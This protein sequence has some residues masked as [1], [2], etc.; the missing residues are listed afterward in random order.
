MLNLITVATTHVS[1]YELG[2]IVVLGIIDTYKKWKEEKISK[3]LAPKVE[4]LIEDY[5]TRVKVGLQGR[6][7]VK[8]YSSDVVGKKWLDLI[9]E[10][11]EE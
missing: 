2:G 11:W 8:K 1:F 9:E 10:K 4:D 7:T 3:L 6:R 5:D